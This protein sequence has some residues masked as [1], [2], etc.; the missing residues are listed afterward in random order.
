M[1]KL[2]TSKFQLWKASIIY[3]VVCE[4]LHVFCTELLAAVRI[5]DVDGRHP[6]ALAACCKVGRLES[7]V[8]RGKL[9]R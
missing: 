2:P 8:S 1:V 9:R 4:S 5:R 6:Q 7:L 3:S